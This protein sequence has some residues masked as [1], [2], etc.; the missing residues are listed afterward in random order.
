MN[1]S[2]KGPFPLNYFIQSLRSRI[3][4]ISI[5]AITIIV[6][7]RYF[8]ENT[9]RAIFWAIVTLWLYSAILTLFR[10]KPLSQILARL[11]KMKVN[12]AHT[13]QI[14]L[15]YRKN[16]WDIINFML[17]YVDRE[18]HLQKSQIENQQ[19]KANH[20]IASVSSPIVVIDNYQNI[21]NQMRLLRSILRPIRN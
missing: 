1:N 18:I 20:I 6:I 21:P 7:D 4:Y 2:F 19:I 11:E 9:Y 14:E 3:F 8:I 13:D 12:L 15:L 17:D 10:T 5:T 16:E